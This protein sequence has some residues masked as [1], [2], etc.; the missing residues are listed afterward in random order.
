MVFPNFDMHHVGKIH[1]NHWKS[2]SVN[3]PSLKAIHLLSEQRYSSAKLQKFTDVCMVQTSVKLRD[4]D[5]LY[6][7]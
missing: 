5:E 1:Q 2:T 6:L 4:F 3:L 7:C